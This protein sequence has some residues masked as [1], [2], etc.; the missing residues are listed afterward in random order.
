MIT[1]AIPARN[2]G[3][4]FGRVLEAVLNQDI[5]E[6]FEI[7]VADTESS[8]GTRERVMHLAENNDNFRWFPVKKADF[9]HGKTRNLLVEKARGDVVAFLTQDALPVDRNWLRNLVEP[10]R[11]Q[12]D[13]AGATGLHLAYP[14][15]GP[16]TARNMS[17]HFRSF[18]DELKL[19]RIDDR[20][21]YEM[22]QAYRQHLHFYSDNNSAM[23]REVWE[24]IP[25]LEVPFG[26]DQLWAEKILQA[27][28]AKAWV[29]QAAVFHSH[30]FSF[31]NTVARA[32]EEAIY[33]H[34]VFGYRLGAPL[35]ISLRRA[36]IQWRAD[37]H[38]M[39]EQGAIP[40]GERKATAI[41]IFGLY[42]GHWLARREIGIK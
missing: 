32:K 12:R 1:V 28:Y 24:K 15:H 23:I 39:K 35:G 11:S 33:Y 3:A 37:C 30:R 7:L 22:D 40:K 26:E 17:H 31:R 36:W 18:G 5:A 8:D 38:W 10:L 20:E 34:Q 14:E 27:G 29:P 21:L 42:L 25:Y 4:L 2:G 16:I 9:G 41:D 13:V 6:E 19:Q